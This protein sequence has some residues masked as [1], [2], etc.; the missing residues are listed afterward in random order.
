MRLFIS[1]ATEQ[2]SVADAILV[3]LISGAAGDFLGT[4]AVPLGLQGSKSAL[5]TP[6][7]LFV[8][9][10]EVVTALTFAPWLA[11]SAALI[12]YWLMR[13]QET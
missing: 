4:L 10:S 12:A 7:M 9:Q 2:K 1:Y 11:T 3:S 5:E 8:Q 6:L 13:G